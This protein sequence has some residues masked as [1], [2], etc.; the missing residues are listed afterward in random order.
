LFY[1]HKIEEYILTVQRKPDESV[2]IFSTRSPRRP[3][4]IGMSIVKFTKINGNII[5]FTGV[6]MLDGTPVLD[7]KPYNEALNP[8]LEL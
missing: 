7:I 8:Q 1:L 4:K 3:N 6:D 2:G 5:E